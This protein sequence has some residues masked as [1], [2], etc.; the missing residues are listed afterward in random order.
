MITGFLKIAG[1]PG[2]SQLVGH[3]DEIEVQSLEFRM[4]APAD[5]G[6]RRGRVTLGPVVLRKRYDVASPA[7]QLAL[8]Q[9]TFFREATF[10]AVRTV[11]GEARDD[12]V[13]IMRGASLQDF[14]IAPSPDV[15]E[16]FDERIVLV[17]ERIAFRSGGQEVDLDARLRT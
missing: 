9:N 8:F 7:L 16:V 6:G 14:E 1:I 12:L 4:Q 2:G 17:Y 13:V 11:E 3:E 5:A 15:S 10:T